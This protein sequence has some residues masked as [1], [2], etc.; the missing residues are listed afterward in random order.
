MTPQEWIELLANLFIFAGAITISFSP[1]L[2]LKPQIYLFFLLG[3]IFWTLAGIFY[4]DPWH[5][6]IVMLNATF[7]VVDI[8]AIYK[9]IG[10]TEKLGVD[11]GNPEN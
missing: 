3:H 7:I 1:K 10:L 4:Y 11:C 9:R 2:S 8:Y 6:R 5:W